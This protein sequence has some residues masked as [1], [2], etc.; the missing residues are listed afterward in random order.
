MTHDIQ[1][2][3]DALKS[4]ETEVEKLQCGLICEKE[5]I[6]TLSMEQTNIKEQL[7]RAREQKRSLEAELDSVMEE[8]QEKVSVVSVASN[9]R[10]K[11]LCTHAV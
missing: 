8:S 10:M 5:Q 3:N 6:T 11:F 9:E 2:K 7:Q 1:R 4:F